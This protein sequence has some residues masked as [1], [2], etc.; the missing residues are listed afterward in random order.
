M[1]DREFSTLVDRVAPSVP[2]C[3]HPTV[4]NAIRDAARR[5]CERTL[6]WRYAQPVTNLL[7]GVYEYTYERP[8]H[9]EV[10]ALFAAIVNGS[11]LGHLTLEQALCKYPQWAEAYSGTDPLSIWGD[12]PSGALNAYLFNEGLFNENPGFILPEETMAAASTPRDVCQLTPDKFV[13][14]P[15]PDN[16][17]TYM[18][19]MI[20]ALKPS[21]DATGMDAYVF[22]ELEE[23][24]MHGAL[25]QLLVMPQ[26]N[27]SDRELASYHAKQFLFETT[28]RRARAN[29]GNMRGTLVATGTGF[30]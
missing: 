29:L 16:A 18:V 1:A 10:H 24:L 25:Q 8:D 28:S 17:R 3:P 15:L 12:T 11:P 27:W 9:T 19:R 7:P 22:D 13:V 5:V 2:G 6:A 14:L 30:A 23:A 20:Y 26:V 4:I 21:R